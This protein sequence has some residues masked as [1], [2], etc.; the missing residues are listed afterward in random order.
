VNGSGVLRRLLLC[1]VGASLA[2]LM[3]PVVAL[4]VVPSTTRY[5]TVPR[6]VCRGPPV[7]AGGAVGV[8]P[9]TKDVAY[10][11]PLPAPPASAA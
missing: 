8:L 1:V 4:G 6:L 7:R 9:S 5:S 11:T 3:A 2:R 10:G